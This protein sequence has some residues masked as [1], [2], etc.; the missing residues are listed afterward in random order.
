[1]T[2]FSFLMLVINIFSISGSFL[3]GQSITL[4]NLKNQIL[5]FVDLLYHFIFYLFFYFPL[6]IYLLLPV[7]FVSFLLSFL[8]S[9]LGRLDHSPR[10]QPTDQMYVFLLFIQWQTWV[11]VIHTIVHKAKIFV[12]IEKVCQSLAYITNFRYWL[13]STNL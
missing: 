6:I 11:A 8:I 2:N 7:D 9:L 10:L 13:S 5:G 4:N 1:M 12:I 3:L